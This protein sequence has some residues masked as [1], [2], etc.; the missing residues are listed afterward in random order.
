MCFCGRLGVYCNVCVCMYVCAE[1]DSNTCRV[2]GIYLDLQRGV[3][4]P[5]LRQTETPVGQ[6][7]GVGVCLIYIYIC[8]EQTG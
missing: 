6:H 5:G 7:N 2:D 3:S 8:V 4:V 1:I